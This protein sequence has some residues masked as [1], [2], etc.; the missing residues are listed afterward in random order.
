MGCTY[1]KM[2]KKDI[3]AFYTKEKLDAPYLSPYGKTYRE[4]RSIFEF[5]EEDL[6]ITFRSFMPTG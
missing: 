4:Y 2:Q 3:E 1:I 5:E 6:E